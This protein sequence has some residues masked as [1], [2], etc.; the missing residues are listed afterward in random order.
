MV[1]GSRTVKEHKGVMRHS[2]RMTGSFRHEAV[3]PAPIDEQ[4][5]TAALK[6]GALSITMPESTAAKAT[7]IEVK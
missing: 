3:L 6:D 7:H 2:T 4:A 1:R 5:V